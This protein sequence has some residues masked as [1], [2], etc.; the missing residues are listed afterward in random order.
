MTS[1]AQCPVAPPRRYHF[2]IVPV[3]SSTQGTMSSMTID[4]MEEQQEPT[5]W[6]LYMVQ[7]GAGVGKEG[8]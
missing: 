8:E 5:D 4:H 3:S 1:N 7:V 6:K 2:D